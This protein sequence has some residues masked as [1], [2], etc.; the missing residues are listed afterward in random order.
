AGKTLA[1]LK[2]RPL[3]LGVSCPLGCAIE[4]RACRATK[5]P[6]DQA[7]RYHHQREGQH[8]AQERVDEMVAHV[9]GAHLKVAPP[10]PFAERP[11]AAHSGLHVEHRG[12]RS[13]DT[14][15]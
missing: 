9:W 13:G 14:R 8:A 7:W 15:R 6:R 4:C 2:A 12:G 10:P 11:K 3:G 5:A 1:E